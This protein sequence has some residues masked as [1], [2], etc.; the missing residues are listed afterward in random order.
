MAMYILHIVG[1]RPNFMKAAPAMK[2][3]AERDGVTEW[4]EKNM[5]RAETQRRKGKEIV[6]HP[7][8]ISRS[9]PS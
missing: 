6:S 4:V 5:S 1:E 3:L 9:Y 2:A 8:T 7:S